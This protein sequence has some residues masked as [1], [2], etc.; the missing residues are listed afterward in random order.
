MPLYKSYLLLLLWSCK[1]K[2]KGSR[3][4]NGLQCARSVT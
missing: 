3:N 1:H 4:Y 2:D